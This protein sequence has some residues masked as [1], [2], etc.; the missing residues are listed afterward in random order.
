MKEKGFNPRHD[1]DFLFYFWVVLSNQLQIYP[2]IYL[3]NNVPTPTVKYH[4][5]NEFFLKNS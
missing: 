5:I 2:F 3:V 4:F 1:N